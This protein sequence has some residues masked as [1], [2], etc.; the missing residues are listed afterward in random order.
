M[1]GWIFTIQTKRPRSR[2]GQLVFKSSCVQSR[3]SSLSMTWIYL[4]GH[5]RVSAGRTSPLWELV[6]TSPNTTWGSPVLQTLPLCAQCP[7]VHISY[8][9]T[10]SDIF[11]FVL[12]FPFELFHHGR[13]WNVYMFSLRYWKSHCRWLK[14][15]GRPTRTT[16]TPASRWSPYD[17]TSRWVFT[18]C[19]LDFA[20]L[21]RVEWN[22]IQIFV[23]SDDLLC[24]FFPGSGNSDWIH[25]WSVWVPRTHRSGKGDSFKLSIEIWVHICWTAEHFVFQG[26][27][28]EFNQCQTQLKAL[29]KEVPSENIGEFTAYR[30]LYYI[31]TKNTG[32]TMRGFHFNDLSTF[33]S[34][35]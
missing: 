31:F 18:K 5:R 32:G 13:S 20:L 22:Q 9:S 12:E 1:L 14:A 19:L 27:H 6:R 11:D 28:E 10:W 29:Y 15:T 16:P 25:S 17:R 33:V 2:K 35:F 7:W 3:W 4:T 23:F 21:F 26:D 8:T 24:L 34:A 30:L